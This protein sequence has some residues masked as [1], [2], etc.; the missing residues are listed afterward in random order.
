VSTIYGV[1]QRGECIVRGASY[2][3]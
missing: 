2:L 3:Y 1:T